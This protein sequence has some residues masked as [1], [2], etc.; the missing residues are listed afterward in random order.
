M[1]LLFLANGEES[2]NPSGEMMGNQT[3]FYQYNQPEA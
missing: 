3:G 2:H 1:E